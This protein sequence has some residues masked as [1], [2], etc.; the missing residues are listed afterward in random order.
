M[1]IAFVS[2]D[3]GE[4]CIQHANGLLQNG[5]V[6]LLMPNQQV[7]PH[8][9][10]LNERVDLRTF[11]K[12]RLRDPVNQIRIIRWI[13]KQINSFNPDVVHF[14]L[15]HLWFNFALPLLRRR[16]PIVFT[17]HDPRQHLGDRGA[18]NTP[19]WIMDFG[20]RRADKVIV[21]GSQLKPVLVESLGIANQNIFVIPFRIGRDLR[22]TRMPARS[23]TTG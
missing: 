5:E 16:Y 22:V 13:M 18:K 9:E 19:Q 12:P 11:S 6:L 23:T 15:G 3:F 21:H 14:Q 10:M 2:Y 17:I 8:R 1:K 4:Y 7:E 20:F